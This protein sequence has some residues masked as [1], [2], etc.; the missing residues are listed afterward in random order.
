MPRNG[1]GTYTAPASSVNPA[2]TNTAI[3][4]A[5]FN[6][7][8]TDLATAMT[9]SI[10]ANGETPITANIP[11]AG[12]KHTGLAAGTQNG[13][14]VRYEQISGFQPLDA[15]LTAFAALTTADNTMLDFTG[16]DTMA[17][18]SYATVLSNIGAQA[19]LG[20]TAANDALAAHLA[21]TES[22]TGKKTMSGVDL[23][24]ETALTSHVAASAG[25]I[26]TVLSAFS[27]TRTLA[28]VDD[29]QTL[30]HTSGSAH[31]LTIDSNANLALPIGF[32]FSVENE[33][34]GGDVTIAITTDTLRWGSSTGSRT[35][36]AN[37]TA[38]FK[39][40]AATLWRMTGIGIT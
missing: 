18:I 16:V 20:Y 29:G 3:G 9:N 37:G 23:V 34:G 22:F 40:V 35:L 27:G 14:S 6:A 32:M 10:A 38:Y 31:T 30:Y 36:A 1:S 11:M 33:N 39:K 12:H 19:S 5:A 25:Y 8:T 17:V 15:T 24:L 28:N 21:G 4:S 2:V 7:Q 13:D 26:G